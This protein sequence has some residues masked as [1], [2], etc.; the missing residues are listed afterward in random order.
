MSTV[1]TSYEIAKVKLQ[2]EATQ[3]KEELE[4]LWAKSEMGKTHI[5]ALVAKHRLKL[6]QK[7]EE[8]LARGWKEWS[9]QAVELQVL[10][11][12]AKNHQKEGKCFFKMDKMSINM[13]REDLEEDF[14]ALADG[15]TKAISVLLEEFNDDQMVLL[16][17]AEQAMDITPTDS[18][19]GPSK[20]VIG[21][22]PN[23]QRNEPTD[24]R[25]ND[26]RSELEIVTEPTKGIFHILTED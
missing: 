17:A 4:T 9:P 20:L 11:A 23:D 24:K 16:I 26:V 15:H 22:S 14:H 7:V 5:R 25:N 2:M 12:D 8:A 18:D 13:I 3:A 6:N 1:T 21:T 19:E 10:Q